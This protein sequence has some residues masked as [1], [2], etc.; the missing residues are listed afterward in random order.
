MSFLTSRAE[1]T[2]G[3]ASLSQKNLPGVLQLPGHADGLQPGR[4]EQQLDDK[5]R[6]E[7]TR[8]DPRQ[9]EPFYAGAA[10]SHLYLR[11]FCHVQH[12]FPTQFDGVVMFPCLS[13]HTLQ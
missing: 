4:A 12:L 13:H 1:E 2:I 9:I 11:W 10:A 8:K 6:T 3:G 7:E 5:T